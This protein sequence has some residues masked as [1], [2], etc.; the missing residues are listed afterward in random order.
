M[1]NACLVVTYILMLCGFFAT[2]GRELKREREKR[3]EREREIEQD[4]SITT[5]KVNLEGR[6][7]NVM[8]VKLSVLSIFSSEISFSRAH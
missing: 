2:S 4:I 1:N 7:S 3:G 6:N 5:L 8:H